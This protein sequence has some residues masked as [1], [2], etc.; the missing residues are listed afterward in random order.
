VVAS[1]P[2]GAA[3]GARRPARFAPLAIEGL[4]SR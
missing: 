3:L 2:L 4:W 1:A